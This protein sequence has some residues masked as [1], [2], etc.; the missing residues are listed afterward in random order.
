MTSIPGGFF[1]WQKQKISAKRKIVQRM[2]I[3]GGK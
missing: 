1:G 3:L 2:S